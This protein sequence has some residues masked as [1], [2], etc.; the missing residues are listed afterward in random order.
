[1]PGKL[2]YFDV[3]GR[4]DPIRNLLCHA[5]FQ[6]EEDR[7]SFEQFGQLKPTGVFPLGSM[8][9][10]EEDGF[11]TVQSNA[12]LRML[13]IRL[14]YYPEDPILAWNC[15]SLMDFMEDMQGKKQG[16]MSPILGG[17]TPPLEGSDEWIAAY[18]DTIFSL[19]ENR[20]KQ[21]GKKYVAGTDNLTAADFKV[22]YSVSDTCCNQSSALLP[23]VLQKVRDCIAKYPSVARWVSTMESDC[24]RYLSERPP[25]PA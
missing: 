20:F 18:Y 1:M 25:R 2:T 14:G 3:N 16:Y 19:L 4:A 9:V 10:W 15:D 6:Y 17:Q 11:K 21:H 13:A 12:I 8:P 7:L 24:Q 22:F 23:E 5:N